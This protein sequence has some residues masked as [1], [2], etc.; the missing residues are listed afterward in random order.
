MRPLIRILFANVS[1]KSR[2]I[3]LTLSA[4][5]AD[6]ARLYKPMDCISVVLRILARFRHRGCVKQGQFFLYPGC[7][8][9]LHEFRS[10][11]KSTKR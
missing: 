1:V 7:D 6:I 11:A 2:Q 10:Y 3:P 5:R 8:L 4:R 9:T